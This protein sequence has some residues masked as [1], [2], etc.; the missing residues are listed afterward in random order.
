MA[1]QQ[2]QAFEDLR[3]T[4]NEVTRIVR[5]RWR[6]S[7]VGLS[8]VGAVAFWCSQYLP[9]EY[10][11]S[12][13]FERR[14][15]VVLQNLIQRNSPYGFEHLK[16]TMR[17]DMTG[18][19]AAAKALVAAG[20]LPDDTLS[21]DPTLG[22]GERAAVDRALGRFKLQP[23]VKLIHST[24]SLDT[25]LLTCRSNDPVVARKMVVALRD[26]YIADTRHRIREILGGTKEFFESEVSRLQQQVIDAED[27]LRKGFEAF[28]GVDPSDLAAVGNRVEMLRSQRDNLYQRQAALE[29]D[30]NAREEFLRSN[31]PPYP[32]KRQT[33]E[34]PL[35]TETGVLPK[36]ETASVTLDRALEKVQQAI[37]DAL[38]VQRMTMEHP[39]VKRL[40]AR[41][42]ALRDLR[43]SLYARAEA[44]A[45]ADAPHTEV[46]ARDE[47]GTPEH[48][49]AYLQWQ[50]Q[51]ARVELELDSLGRQLATATAQLTEAE[52]RLSEFE[53]LYNRLLQEDDSMRATL[54][55]RAAA[56]RELAVWQGHLANLERILA[57]ESGERGTQFTLLEEPED[58]VRPYKPRVA[59]IFVVCSGLG[60]AAAA[61]LV[62]LAELFDRSFRSVGQVTRVLGVPVLECI[63]VVRTPREKRR[64]A[65]SRIVWTPT[66]GMLLLCLAISAALAYTSLQMPSVHAR[67]MQRFDGVLQSVGV[68]SILPT[69]PDTHEGDADG[70]D[71]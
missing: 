2:G 54:E 46:A 9:R 34:G 44:D 60:L 65:F 61:L 7:L 20:L 70:L 14:D 51:Q 50:A 23:A 25:I 5:H 69:H 16:T 32:Y 41:L 35:T 15:D 6:F 37:V 22:E 71:V 64:V 11:A 40:Y 48:S 36:P 27:Q 39:T 1:H 45:A 66:L 56:N 49:D 38:T 42:D 24:A 8:I 12:T 52:T 26:T 63:G 55:Q 30:V 3:N 29:A 18:S 68:T 13:M 59:S 17:M 53:R 31:P 10:S 28:P 47:T 19:R 62:A 58:V 21:D 33:A 43:Q 4:I 67:A 57:A